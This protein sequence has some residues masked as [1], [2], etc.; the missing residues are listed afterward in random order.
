MAVTDI[1]ERAI[2][3]KKTTI[4]SVACIATGKLLTTKLEPILMIPNSCCNK[5]I[6]KPVAMP[7]TTPTIDIISPSVKKMLRISRLSAP[8]LCRVLMSLR[9]S[10]ISSDSDATRFSVAISIMSESIRNIPIR[11]DLNIL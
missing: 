9:L 1:S 7:I 11:S 4:K 10:I 6:T 8:M 3:R 2:T 5:H